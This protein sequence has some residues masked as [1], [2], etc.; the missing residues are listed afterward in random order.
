MKRKNFV[1]AVAAIVMTAAMS[2]TAFAAGWQQNTTGWWYA[3]NDSGTE[4]YSNGWQWIDGDFD[5]VEECYYFDSNGYMLVNT[6]T[7]DGYTV[8]GDGAWV[9]NGFVET[10]GTPCMR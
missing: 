10:K 3:T 1:T 9:T 7:P 6:T 8:N 5:G 2:M 4:W